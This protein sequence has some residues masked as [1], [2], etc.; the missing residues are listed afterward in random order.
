MIQALLPL[1]LAAAALAPG[2]DDRSRFL[3]LRTRALAEAGQRHLELG[4]DLRREGLCVQA[5]EQI[6]RAVEVSGGQNQGALMVLRL[7]QNLDDGFWKKKLL[8]PGRARLDSYEHEAHRLDVADEKQRLEAALWAWTHRLWEDAHAE[9]VDILTRRGEPLEFTKSGCVTLEAGTLPEK[10]SQRIRE[11]AVAINDKL[12]IR[13]RFLAAL[14]QLK[15]LFEQRDALLCVRSTRSLDEARSVHA[16]ALQ[17]LPVLEADLGAR[18]GRPLMLVLLGDVALYEAYLDAVKMPEHKAA[19]GFADQ[20]S[21]I[22]VVCTA[23]TAGG[24][25]NG[26]CLHELTH[27]YHFAI[28]RSSMPSWY[29]E[30]LAECYGG[31]GVFSLVEG[32]LDFGGSL[33]AARLDT[34][35]AAKLPFGLR[36]LLEGNATRLLG[37]DPERAH[38]FYAESWAF[39]RFL[40]SGA[41]EDVARR[42]AQW[43]TTCRGALVDAVIAGLPA[44]RDKPLTSSDLF[45]K[46]FGRDLPKLEDAFCA[47]LKKL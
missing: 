16:L 1:A 35:R 30:G 42:F 3:A 31:P 15:E 47:W 11:E 4:V 13:D 9:Y 14:P 29:S 40:R 34:L 45:L 2:D 26:T 28:S 43:E 7:M 33:P 21:G 18:P 24:D 8:R 12:Y 38:A 44:E 5:A 36:E 10:E 27:L 25:G 37:S 19:F 32:K 22:A 46:A 6:V 17:L 20:L 23:K 41:G 39:V